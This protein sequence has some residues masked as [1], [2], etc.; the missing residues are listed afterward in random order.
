MNTI[1]RAL[2]QSM[3]LPLAIGHENLLTILLRG[4]DPASGGARNPH[5]LEYVPVPPRRPPPADD[6]SPQIVS[7]F[8]EKKFL[9][10]G[11]DLASA[12]ARN[13]HG[14]KTTPVSPLQAPPADGLAVRS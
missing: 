6:L 3:R 12:G 4:H 8:R 1:C 13:P 10:R 14:L 5:V 2:I 11:H 7:R 9:L